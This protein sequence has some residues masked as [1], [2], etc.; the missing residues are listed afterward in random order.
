MGICSEVEDV[1]ER[2]RDAVQELQDSIRNGDIN[3]VYFWYVHNM[4]E[5]NNPE[6]QE[7]LNTV[8][9]AS[10]KLV[11]AFVG[12]NSVKIV[13]LEV[14]NNTIEKW[15]N[16]SNK[17]ISIEEQLAVENNGQALEI[18]EENWYS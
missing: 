9:V 16:N 18:V 13:A 2:I 8:Q 12:D 17:R 7:E 10:Q 3:T 14:G 4:N 15:Y 6:V 5:A 1:P 11:S